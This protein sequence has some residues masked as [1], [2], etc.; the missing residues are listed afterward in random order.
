MF[1]AADSHF[2]LAISPSQ[3]NLK[4]KYLNLFSAV[5]MGNHLHQVAI[6]KPTF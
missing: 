2:L 1:A 5:F 6:K 3:L 4:S